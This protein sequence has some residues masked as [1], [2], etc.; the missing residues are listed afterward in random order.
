MTGSKEDLRR[1]LRENPEK[2]NSSS[3]CE[4]LLNHPW[5][6][7]A[8]TIMAFM[9]KY[10][11]PDIMPV[12]RDILQKGKQLLLPRCET[13]QTMTAR[14]VKDLSELRQGSFGLP[15]PCEEAEAVP[16][17]EIQLILVPG[18]AFDEEGHRLGH[19]MGYYDYFLPHTKAKTIGVAGRVLPFVP[20]LQ[21]DRDMDSLVTDNKT[22]LWDRRTTHVGREAEKDKTEEV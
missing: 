12:L 1:F 19:G 17:E 3:I 21:T 13:K 10:P 16:P 11:E 4:R 2:P 7:E 8:K 14:R 5:Y 22:I 9:P 6:L 15:E 20:T 18:L